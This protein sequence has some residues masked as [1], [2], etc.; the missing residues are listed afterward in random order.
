M[1]FLIVTP[2]YHP[3]LGASAP[4][5]RMLSNELVALGHE[6]T[7]IANVPHYPSGRVQADFKKR[8]IQRTN[9]DGIQVVRIRIPSVDRS[10][11]YM[12]YLQ[13][14]I[15][16]VGAAIASLGTRFDIGLYTNPGMGIWLPFFINTTLRRIP[17]IFS[18]HDLYP[19]VG[20]SLGIFRNR[21]VIDV[22][23]WLEK[24]CLKRARAVRILSDSFLDG[25]R[26][27]GVPDEKISLI[28][29]WVDTDLIHP[30]QQQ[31]GFVAE[32][33]LQEKFVVMYA[34]NVGLSQGLESV[35]YAAQKLADH[36]AIQFVM[37]GDGA[38]KKSL[39]D[40]A[41]EMKLENVS[42]VPF[43]PR[44]RLAEVLG[45]ADIS[46]VPLRQG[47]AKTAL[48]SKIYSIFASGK[49]IIASV[50]E[51]SETARLIAQS[52]SGICIPPEDIE[53]LANTI[54]SFLQKPETRSRMGK[55]GREWAVKYHSSR[56]A[57]L[58][59]EK[60]SR[61]VIKLV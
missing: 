9:E 60:L 4:L 48:P 27:L 14:V 32:Y 7:V 23:T 37:V 21:F 5:F 35:L 1:K 19:H 16:Q 11:L 24:Y 39:V 20:V 34:G 28:Y 46:L 17:A 41:R 12:R 30:L 33:H 13:W 57:A 3:D 56:A 29:D 58:A 45:A 51:G 47:V 31:N 61:S 10:N 38:G 50:D 59:I 36:K 2:Y 8:F 22:V 43:Q 25:M 49:P 40:L 44:E 55:H 26:E 18:I 6:V 52:G 53:S 42:F 54:T 15:F